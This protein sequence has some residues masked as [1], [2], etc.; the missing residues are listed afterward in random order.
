[1]CSS[2]NPLEYKLAEANF[3]GR[4]EPVIPGFDLAGIVIGT[5]QDVKINAGLQAMK[6]GKGLIEKTAAIVDPSHA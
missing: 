6:A 3:L 2:L 4:T 1:M 5:G